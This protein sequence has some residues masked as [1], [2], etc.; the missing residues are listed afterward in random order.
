M[1]LAARLRDA[2]E[3]G[4]RRRRSCSKATCSKRGSGSDAGRRARRRGRPPR[5]ATVILTER[6]ETMRKHPGQ[7]SFPAGPHRP[8]DDGPVAAALREAERRSPS[9]AEPSSW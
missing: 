5:R 2:L 9:R 4:R 6:P 8:G 1:S 3:R 7:I